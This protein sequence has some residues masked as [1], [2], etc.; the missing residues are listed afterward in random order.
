MNQSI[1]CILIIFTEINKWSLSMKSKRRAQDDESD[2]FLHFAFSA[3]SPARSWVQKFYFFLCWRWVFHGSPRHETLIDIQLVRRTIKRPFSVPLN[4]RK[5]KNKHWMCLFHTLCAPSVRFFR[6]SASRK[7]L[8]QSNS[9][10]KYN[11]KQYLWNLQFSQK[12]KFSCWSFLSTA[13]VEK[14]WEAKGRKKTRTKCSN[15]FS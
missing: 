13:L 9:F 10:L 2:S 11:A 14:W 8:N 15:H 3:T 6:F 1:V 4:K 12:D 7:M 5:E